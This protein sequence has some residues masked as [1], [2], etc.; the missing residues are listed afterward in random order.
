[1]FCSSCITQYIGI[2]LQENL[3]SIDCPEPDCSDYL[4]PEKCI[5]ILPKETIQQWSLALMEAKRAI[6]KMTEIHASFECDYYGVTFLL[7]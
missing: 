1:M 7:E 4:T 5:A 2:K 6:A 3:V